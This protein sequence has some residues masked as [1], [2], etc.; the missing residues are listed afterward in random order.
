MKSFVSGNLLRKKKKNIKVHRNRVENN[1]QELGQ[2]KIEWSKNT[3]L[4]L[5]KTLC[6]KKS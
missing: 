2:V 6:D 1:Y 3:N 5:C 4:K